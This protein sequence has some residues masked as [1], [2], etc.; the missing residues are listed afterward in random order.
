[1]ECAALSN[2]P[3]RTNPGVGVPRVGEGLPVLIPNKSFN[4]AQ[5]S[6]TA[7]SAQI[8]QLLLFVFEMAKY[9]RISMLQ[10]RLQSSVVHV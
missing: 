9:I 1:V 6:R 4:N 2:S 7:A 3:N 5:G 8:E 10:A